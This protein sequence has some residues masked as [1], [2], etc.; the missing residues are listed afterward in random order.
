MQEQSKHNLVSPAGGDLTGKTV[1][2]KASCFCEGVDPDKELFVCQRGFGC[3]P[4]AMGTK[5][6]GHWVA[7]GK[8]GWIRRDHILGVVASEE[9]P[10]QCDCGSEI[11]SFMHNCPNCSN[12]PEIVGCPKC[13]DSCPE[14][15][16]T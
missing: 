9:T 1:R 4:E 3:S 5:I 12:M 15:Q 10:K 16:G 11:K 6:F 7:D 2:L 13:D 14:C 8:E